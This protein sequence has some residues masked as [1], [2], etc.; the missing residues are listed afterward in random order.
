MTVTL[1]KKTSVLLIIRLFIIMV[2]LFGINIYLSYL[3]SFK[4]LYGL[5]V[6]FTAF[7]L[8]SVFY[9]PR[10]VASAKIV[11]SSKGI[12]VSYGVF[13]KTEHI[14]PMLRL[15]FTETAETPL[16]R[17]F[18]LTSISFFGAKARVNTP[19]ISK[20]DALKI[21]KY[22]ESEKVKKYE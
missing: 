17:A 11:V 15:I 22:I 8:I 18:G 14:L 2:A 1:P 13:I 12:T 5:A 10:F 9:I 20:T 7:L 4:L 21:T 6:I 3:I 16:S 19:E